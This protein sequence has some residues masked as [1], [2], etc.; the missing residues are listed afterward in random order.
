[1]NL[2]AFCIRRPAF[3]IVISLVMIIIG[4]IGYMNLPVRW[5]PNVT[6]PQVSISVSYP[7]ANA[8]L[9]ERDVTK[10]IEDSLS[11]ING[12]ETLTSVSRQGYS[13]INIKF[14]LGNNMDAAVE[15]VRSSIERVRSNLPRDVLNPIVTKANPNTESILY[16]S[17]NDTHRSE[18]ELGDY[19][20]KFILPSFETIDGVASVWVF[21]KRVSAMKISLDPSKM[22][23]AN[24]TADEVSQ[25]LHEQNA[26]IPSG[27]IRAQDRNYSVVADTS[28]K[29]AIQFNDL[30]IRDNQNQIV[31]LKD[32][33]NAKIDVED[34]DSSFRING[35]PG[36]ALGV[37]PQSTANPLEV[38]QRI[39][40]VFSELQ[41]TLPTGMEA[42]IIFNQA[43]FIRASIHSVYE[44]FIE[45]VIFVWIVILAFLCSFRA[46]LIPIITIPVCLIST[47]ALIHFFGFSINTLTLMALVLAIGLVVDDAIVMLENISRHMEE[48][49]SA[50]EAAFKG[51]REM[52]F[53]IIAMTLTLAAVYAPIA[54]TPG[55]LGV[56]FREFT[57]TLAGAVVI[58]G[59][60]ALTLSPMMCAR[61][62]KTEKP[63]GYSKWQ[64]HQLSRLQNQ[65]QRAL[66][67][68]LQKRVWVV[69]GLLLIAGMGLGVY[70]YLSSELAPSEDMN[71]LF[72]SI[73]GPHSASSQYTDSYVKQMEEVYTQIPE[74][75]SYLSMGGMRSPS[76]AFQLLMLKPNAKRNRSTQQIIAA[77]TSEADKISGV[78]INVFAPQP[79]LAE[80]AG[81]D[82][83]DSLGLVMMTSSDYRNLQQTSK[84]M[85]DA[86]K[87]LPMFLHVENSL[88]WDS[89]QFQVNVDREKA[90]DLHVTIPTITNT[91]STLIA[92]KIVGKTNDSNIWLQMNKTSLE[93][94]NVFQQ[95]Y[96]RNTDGKMVPLSS[97]LEISEATTSEVYRHNERLRAD[98][99]YLTLAPT[100]KVSE[101]INALQKVVKENLPEDMK[102]NYTG[103]AKSFLESSGKTVFTFLLA[104][105]FIYL[106]LVAQFES[107]IDPLVILFTVPFAVV[108][109]MLTLKVFGGT[110]NIYSNIGLITLVGLIAKHGILITD[111]ANRIR[112]TGKSIQDAII[113]AAM[114]RLRPIL[115][116]TAAMVLGTLPLAFAFGPGSESRQ[117]VGLVIAG[118]LVFGTFFSLIVVPIA[119]T[120]LAPFRKIDSIP[121][122]FIAA[123]NEEIALTSK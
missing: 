40:K 67:F 9:V 103:E 60:V 22:A 31:R 108:G 4:I 13:E 24:V 11:G 2:P 102:F 41:R 30:I 3:T 54:F 112:A 83:G 10:I 90:A 50:S 64:A 19:I 74:I 96:V 18:R 82:E 94:P 73:A 61:I 87:E 81:S 32:I 100:Y 80:F 52:I 99:I 72:V 65:Y 35:K 23:A 118:G 91:L 57:F 111:F 117:Q 46:T 110:L 84:V 17:F 14:K 70:K 107:F 25:L 47:F 86:I 12:M 121:K 29:S 101:A 105:I 76:H 88:K 43:D 78:R 5:I 114:L 15:D 21:G 26:S 27:Q 7:G 16:V 79:P 85:M 123:R 38:E 98:T 115:M 71:I 95:L 68:I 92:G 120:Y 75:D 37:V 119:Y 109:A 33:G 8:R 49:M 45:A 55:L 104:L 59:I 56:L 69:L 6:S 66:R 39:Q 1:M 62:L 53:P 28:L 20:D 51:S 36:I 93:N 122:D 116:T 42:K 34:E 44:S 106:V 89:E 113:E 48:G 97:M 63:S 58:S 77:L